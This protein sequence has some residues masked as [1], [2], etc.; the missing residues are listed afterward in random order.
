MALESGDRGSSFGTSLDV[1]YRSLPNTTPN[2]LNSC[3]VQVPCLVHYILD[4][5]ESSVTLTGG[6]IITPDEET[7][8]QAGEVTCPRSGST[9][10]PRA[11]GL[12]SALPAA[13]IC[14]LRTR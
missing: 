10:D 6:S 12:N 5:N 2:V 9:E 1:N 11:G 7:E 4:C 13:S 8:A 14:C 3:W